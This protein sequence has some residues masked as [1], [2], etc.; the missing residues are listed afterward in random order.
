MHQDGLP[1]EF[2]EDDPVGTVW[3]RR[4]R[5]LPPPPLSYRKG[6]L[7]AEA[8]REPPEVLDRL[9]LRPAASMSFA[10]QGGVAVVPLCCSHDHHL[11]RSW[12]DAARGRGA[13]GTQAA[14]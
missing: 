14:T 7:H 9:F 8:V 1:E 3:P 4:S 10:P 13:S 11:R 12:S 5:A 6:C 2:L